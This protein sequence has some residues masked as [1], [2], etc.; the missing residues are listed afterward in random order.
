M[1]IESNDVADDCPLYNFDNGLK[2]E[3]NGLHSNVREFIDEMNGKKQKQNKSK[4]CWII[5]KWYIQSRSIL[6]YQVHVICA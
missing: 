6:I 3:I 5:R 1:V 4:Y 2:S